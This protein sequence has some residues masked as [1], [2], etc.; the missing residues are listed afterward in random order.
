MVAAR[1][2]VGQRLGEALRP[3]RGRRPAQRL[4]E[5]FAP[6]LDVRVPE[7]GDQGLGDV[8]DTAFHSREAPNRLES[9]AP[10][11]ISHPMRDRI[12]VAK[13]SRR[14]DRSRAVLRI[15]GIAQTT[16]RCIRASRPFG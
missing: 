11:R 4:A 9:H 6:H 16:K 8:A 5:R 14:P 3:F 1:Q 15:A 7:T 13:E 10:V 2:A 12:F